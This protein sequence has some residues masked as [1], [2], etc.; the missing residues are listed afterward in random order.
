MSAL[1][2]ARRLAVGVVVAGVGV[3]P[4]AAAVTPAKT[5]A[6]AS[7]TPAG[8]DG[9]KL[10]MTYQQLRARRLVGQIHP[11][12]EGGGPDTRAAA[13][14]APLRGSVDFT[15]HA[16]RKVMNITISGGA[17]ARGVGVGATL[18]RVTAAYPKAKIDHSTE[19]T[20]AITLIKVPRSGG[21]RLEF[22]V[23]TKTRR[24]TL[25]GIPFIAFCE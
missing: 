10:G 19:S 15:L 12:C 7:I 25:I 22:A 16:P 4:L 14:R 20:F 13:L 11:G 24:V 18:A 17:Q 21:G 8:V 1:L 9:V 2:P 23:S 5:A 6:P 3:L